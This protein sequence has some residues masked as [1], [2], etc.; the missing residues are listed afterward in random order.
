MLKVGKRVQ[1]LSPT[2]WESVS[3]PILQYLTANLRSLVENEPSTF[4]P[5][6]IRHLQCWQPKPS[7]TKFFSN[8]LCCRFSSMVRVLIWGYIW[9]FNCKKLSLLVEDSFPYPGE[10]MIRY[11]TRMFPTTEIPLKHFSK[12]NLDFIP[13]PLYFLI[14]SQKFELDIISR[15]EFPQFKHF[16]RDRL[17]CG[18]G[19]ACASSGCELL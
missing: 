15:W 7:P 1:G 3:N 2:N 18:E 4:D 14:W 6:A 11:V 5:I 9:P 13:S 10:Q 8:K 17:T 12:Q 19:G 16:S